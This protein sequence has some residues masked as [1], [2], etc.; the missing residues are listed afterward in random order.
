MKF[1]KSNRKNYCNSNILKEETFEGVIFMQLEISFIFENY[2]NFWLKD[3][4]HII[5]GGYK[6]YGYHQLFTL[7]VRT[8]LN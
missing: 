4:S 8:Q 1:L 6:A 2:I 5:H 3:L 7:Y